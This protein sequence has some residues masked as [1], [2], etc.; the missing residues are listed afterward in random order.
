M[1]FRLMPYNFE[2][3]YTDEVS[4][5]LRAVETENEKESESEPVASV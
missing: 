4:R 5:R 2:P 1:C 3:E